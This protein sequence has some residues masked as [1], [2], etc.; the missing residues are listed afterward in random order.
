MCGVLMVKHLL[1]ATAI[2]LFS[3]PALAGEGMMCSGE[4]V[5]THFPMAGGVGFNLLGATIDVGGEVVFATDPSLGGTEIGVAAAFSGNHRIAIDFADANYEQIVAE[6]RLFW[7][8][9]E[10]D[11]VYGGTL[12]I[13]GKGAWAISCGWG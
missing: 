4:G 11:P 10:S 3:L 13:P 8:E 1:L 6:V 2:G 5:E 7:T 12:K 9:E